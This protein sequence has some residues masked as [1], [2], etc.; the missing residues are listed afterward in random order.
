MAI[1]YAQIDAL[2]RQYAGASRATIN[3][4]DYRSLTTALP[5]GSYIK[6]HGHIV[7]LAIPSTQLPAQTVVIESDREVP[8]GQ[9]LVK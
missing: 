7:Y 3:P 9:V 5:A 4:T 6:T 2:V 8:V 1:T